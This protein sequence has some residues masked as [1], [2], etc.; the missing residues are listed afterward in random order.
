[1]PHSFQNVGNINDVSDI[2]QYKE[3]SE[4]QRLLKFI[5][6]FHIWVRKKVGLVIWKTNCLVDIQNQMHDVQDIN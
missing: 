2:V 3:M 5:I 6:I 4:I 1:M